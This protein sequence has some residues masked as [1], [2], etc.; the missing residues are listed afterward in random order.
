MSSSPFNEQYRFGS[1]AWAQ[2]HQVGAAGLF[3]PRGVQ[4]GFLD[5]RPLHLESD[6]P[7]ITI[8]G[9][10]SGKLR[11]LLGYVVCRSPGQRIL[12]LDPRGEL[13]AIS[14]HVHAMHGEQAYIWNPFGLHGLPQHGCNPLDILALDK[15]TF[16][17]DCKFIARALVT[18]TS[19]AEGKYFE[20]RGAGWVEAFLKF[21]VE[22]AGRTS[23]PRL[24][25]IVN[26]VESG[27]GQWP[28]LL[29]AMLQS[30]FDDVR[31]TAGEM[32]VKQQDSQREF[33]SIV[34]EIYANLS[35]L[36]DPTL[37]ASLA[38]E[39]FSLATLCDPHQ[40]AK[41]FLIVPAEYL[42]LFAPLLRLHFMS[43]LLYK[44]RKPEA[45]RV[46]MIV[47]EAGQ[48]G[49]FEA[50]LQSYTYGRGAGIRP[51]AIFQ[52]IGQIVRNF[53]P[54]GVQGFL[55]SAQ[56][57]QFFGVRDYQ[58]AQLVANM[59]GT[60]TLE[61]DDT[62]LQATARCQKVQAF[63]R[64]MSGDD[65]FTAALDVAHFRRAEALRTKQARKLMTEEE[66]LAMPEDRQIL[67]ISGKD[68]P[69]VMANKRPYFTQSS[70]AGLYLPNPYHPPI[71][72]VRLATRFGE[73]WARVIREPVPKTFA[74][75]AQYAAGEWAYVEGYKPT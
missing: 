21:D 48:L 73:R 19:Q 25:A 75:F 14:L 12:F 26:L 16:H 56:M 67:F 1:A 27:S 42:K 29:E 15:P 59:L 2:D 22:R 23:L 46:T 43:T 11:D 63:Q 44:S 24:M 69:P 7:M 53:G 39:D 47:D 37:R 64:L 32:L 55:G 72:H 41:V 13:A 58:T 35:F 31:R 50:L 4:I 36:D 6:A 70:M 34:G 57:R 30:R 60:E 65:P 51:W 61:Y 54:P 9:A 40:V 62:R 18:V 8:G 71:T 45:A 10:G 68:L 17:A 74:S 49:S 20:Q 52:D 66:I 5:R 3:N 38:R 28:D 33:G